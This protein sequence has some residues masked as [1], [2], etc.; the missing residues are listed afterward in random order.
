[1]AHNGLNWAMLTA[2]GL[3]GATAT[4]WPAALGM[5]ALALIGIVLTGGRLGFDPAAPV[6][7]VVPISPDDQRAGTQ[8]PEDRAA[9]S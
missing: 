2:G 5:S 1:M 9:S 4:T 7:P 3:T 6:D 8:L